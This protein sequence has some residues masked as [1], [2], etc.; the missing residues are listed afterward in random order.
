[1]SLSDK[2]NLNYK[3]YGQ[4]IEILRFMKDNPN[5]KKMDVFIEFIS[6]VKPD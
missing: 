1:M 6:S 3:T 4:K 2:R 5:M